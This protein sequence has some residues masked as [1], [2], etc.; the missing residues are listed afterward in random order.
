M[1]CPPRA[2][3]NCS[4]VLRSSAGLQIRVPIPRQRV[5]TCPRLG[6]HDKALVLRLSEEAQDCLNGKVW[7]LGECLVRDKQDDA[8]RTPSPFRLYFL[9]S[10]STF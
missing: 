10:D 3:L 9:S 4:A 8:V 5:R 7:T 6:Q 2:V 1:L